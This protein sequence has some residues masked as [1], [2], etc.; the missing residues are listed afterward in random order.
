[1]AEEEEVVPGRERR[2][3]RIAARLGV[4]TAASVALAVALAA[5]GLEEGETPALFVTSIVALG[6]VAL[7]VYEAAVWGI[8]AGLGRLVGPWRGSTAS[9]PRGVFTPGRAL[10][11]LGAY[12]L[13]SVV[14]VGVLE[15]GLM[16]AG[17]AEDSMTALSPRLAW[18]LPVALASGAL[19]ALGLFRRLATVRDLV[20]ARRLLRRPSEGALVA[21]VLG[22]VVFALFVGTVLPRL[23]PVSDAYTP[24]TVARLAAGGGWARL[25]LTVTAI[26]VAPVAEESL[27]RGVVLEGFLRRYGRHAAVVATT[28]LFGLA[29][30]PDVFGHGPAITAILLGG[31]ALAEL[32]L[33]SGSLVL[34]M[35][36][37]ASYN[38]VVIALSFL[39]SV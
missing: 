21:C 25:W 27:F 38:G 13:G 7:G 3:V 24:G 28:L 18:V 33:R 22:G 14:A 35:A 37:H 6:W 29:H 16:A 17:G 30:L 10:A 19:V 32:R 34:P 1:M 11:V 26:V 12:F 36:A 4:A 5:E 20:V 15:I 23:L 2:G 39:S 31:V 8:A 9:R